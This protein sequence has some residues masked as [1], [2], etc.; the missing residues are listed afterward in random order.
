MR[1]TAILLTAGLSL[2]AVGTA[3]VAASLPLVLAS[4][5]LAGVTRVV[6]DAVEVPATDG[7][8]VRTVATDLWIGPALAAVVLVLWLD[9]TPGEVQALGGMVGLVGMLN[10]FLRPFYHL[11]YELGQR[12]AAL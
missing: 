4:V 5:V 10:Y 8:T 12:L 7:V 9:A 3:G 6:T 11:I 1:A 2:V